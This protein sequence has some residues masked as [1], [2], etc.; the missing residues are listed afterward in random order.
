M[1]NYKIEFYK[2]RTVPKVINNF[3]LDCETDNIASF[4]IQN[5]NDSA[6][7][8]LVLQQATEKQIILYNDEY[9]VMEAK[10]NER[11][12]GVYYIKCFGVANPLIKPIGEVVVIVKRYL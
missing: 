2:V 6:G 7:S 9:F 11:L 3:V 12:R 10:K 4:K 5:Q 1:I 8:E